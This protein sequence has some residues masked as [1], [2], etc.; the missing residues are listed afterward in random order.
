VRTRI[1]RHGV[2]R[3]G[4]VA[5][6]SPVSPWILGRGRDVILFIGPPALILP[7]V[8]L[9]ETVWSGKS[10]YALVMALG[11]L[12]HHLPGMMRAYG[13]RELFRRFRTRFIAAPLFLVTLCAAFGLRDATLAPIL[14]I[15]YFWGVWHGLMQTHGFARI[16]DAKVGSFAASTVRLDRWLCIVWFGA[17]VLFSTSRMHHVLQKFYASGGPAVPFEAV[18]TARV[19]WG[20]LTALVTIAWLVHLARAMRVGRAPSPVKLVFLAASIGFWWISNAVVENLL[21][22]L[23]LFEIFHDVQYLAIVWIYNRRRVE[24]D[25]AIGRFTRFLFRDR[26]ALIVLYVG[27]VFAYGALSFVPAIPGSTVSALFT[28]TLAASTLLHFYFDSFIWK[29]REKPTRAALGLAGGHDIVTERTRGWRWGPPALRWSALVVPAAF[30]AWAGVHPH[31]TQDESMYALGLAFPDYPLAQ[32]N[33]AVFMLSHDDPA[34][35]VRVARRVLAMKTRDV[36]LE[37][38]ARE[39]LRWGLVG[40]G[41]RSLQQGRTREAEPLLREAG[42]LDPQLAARLAHDAR[43]YARR[44]DHRRAAL[45]Y[46]AVLVVEPNDPQLHLELARELSDAARGTGS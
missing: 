11:A 4:A 29:V 45:H 39:N 13:D 1:E 24:T 15:T 31:Q 25:V 16:Y 38:K 23:V 8:L 33:L 14:L 18:E 41:L 9:A 42:A 19:V 12:G 22:G 27:L 35:A 17:G 5:A 6:S 7:S 28:A 36:D 32:N 3:R 37:R 34:G 26:R 21:V 10:L 44:G 30:L 20:A 40:T 43:A 46:R 2:A